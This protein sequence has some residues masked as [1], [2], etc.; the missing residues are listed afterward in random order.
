MG[1]LF[2]T[3]IPLWGPLGW[4]KLHLRNYLHPAENG[5]VTA[6]PSYDHREASHQVWAEPAGSVVR[7]LLG[8]VNVAGGAPGPALRLVQGV[9]EA[10][11]DTVAVPDQR[12]QGP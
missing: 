12:I 2:R 5:A 11:V 6:G 10:G 3:F 4:E 1:W 7:R 8:I 9:A